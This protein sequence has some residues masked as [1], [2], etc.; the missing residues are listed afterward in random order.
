MPGTSPLPLPRDF[1]D[2]IADVAAKRVA[3][4]LPD[5]RQAAGSIELQQSDG[6]GLLVVQGRLSAP[7]P[8]FYFFTRETIPGVAGPLGGSVRF[9]A[10][11]IAFRIEP[12]GKDGAPMLVTHSID[13]VICRN[14]PASNPAGPRANGPSEAPPS[15]P[16]DIAFPEYQEGIIP[17]QSLPG[18]PAVIYIDF[19]GEKGP[20]LG[21]GNY[22]AE[23]T[24][25]MGN[26]RIK[27]IWQRVAED[28]QGFNI[29]VTT[30]RQVFDKAPLGNRQHC[31]VSTT[32]T[33]APNAGGV[34]H[35]YSF[36]SSYD[37]V[38]WVHYTDF[39]ANKRLASLI[40]HEVGHTL[41]L[42]H[43][44]QDPPGSEHVEYYAGQGSGETAWCPIMGNTDFTDLTQWCKGEYAYANNT[45]DDLAII[46]TNNNNVAYRTDDYGPVLATAGYLEILP[47]DS[48][49]N[50]GILEERSD[51]DALRFVT[52]GGF[53]MLTV[54]GVDQGSNVDLLAEIYDSSNHLIAAGNPPALI[55]ATVAATLAAGEYTLRVSGV[56]Y[57]D[58]LI[59]G[60]SDYGCNGAYLISGTVPGGVK[61]ER[62]SVEENRPNGTAVG[63]VI[64][65]GDHGGNPLSFMIASGN[66]GG[67]FAIH[68]TSGAITVANVA[69]L[70][71]EALST[72]W[73]DPAS[74][75]LF[76]A[77][78]DSLNPLKNEAIRVVVTVT[79]VNEAPTFTG[80][81]LT[82]LE[83]TTTGTAVFTFP[84]GD[85][86]HFDFATY[87]I[88]AGNTG[89]AFEI[90][91][92]TG[93]LL[94]AAD[95]EA[96]LVSTYQLSIRAT[97]QAVPPAKVDSLVTIHVLNVP[98][99]YEPGSIVRTYFEE[100]DGT[101]VA[102]LTN[103]PNFPENPYNE[104]FLT[105][106]DG[107]NH[108][109][110]YGSTVRGYLIPPVSGSYTFWISTDD[111]GE[112]WISSNANP[113]G[114]TLR[115]AVNGYSPP[116]Q[117]TKFPSQASAPIT[118]TAG[119]PYY[120][121][122]RQKEWGGG[123][124]VQVAWQ[125]PGIERQIIPGT[126]LVP[127]Y[128][129]YAPKVWE[130][131]FSVR[132]GTYVGAI[133][134]TVPVTDAN[135]RD[136]YSFAITGGT[137]AGVFD[138]DSSTGS[139]SVKAG[140]VLNAAITP[141]YTL[142]VS[143]TDSGTPPLSD[144]ATMTINVVNAATVS[145][146][147]IVQEIWDD[148]YGNDLA[149]FLSDP[150]FPDWPSS[151]WTLSSFDTIDNRAESYGS[152]IRAYVIPPISGT[153]TFYI[154]SDDEGRLLLSN[155]S[156]PASATQIANVPT[157]SDRDEYNKFPE[158]TSAPVNLI[159]GQRYYIETLHKDGCCGDFVQVAWTGPGI[160][161][162]TII[163]GSALQ[164]FDI[165]LP[166]AFSPASYSYTIKTTAPNGTVVGTV[167]ASDP[168]N[169]ELTYA[170]LGGNTFGA[171][172]INPHSGAISVIKSTGLHG[173]ST[174]TLQ[175]GVQDNGTG[176]LYSLKT[177][178]ATATISIVDPPPI[179]QWTLA[180]FGT[181][182]APGIAGYLDN[183][184]HDAWVNLIE[185]ALGLN[186]LLPD[187]GGLVADF[188]TIG[189]DKF[190]RLT[191][192]KNP[193][194]FDIEPSVEVTGDLSAPASWTSAGTTVEI[195][196]P[197]TLR[198]RDNTPVS[199][200]SQRFI[201]LKVMPPP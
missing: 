99:G 71:Y 26:D 14:F 81:E 182:P 61:P 91:P 32:N 73:D 95:L 55:S 145:V 193:T 181:N 103:D 119:T 100:I 133:F 86:D 135:P 161:S 129:N 28:F 24:P 12:V 185:Y 87:S 165:N 46:A 4:T 66:T 180:K 189:P 52:T 18:A 143:V 109:D 128:Q 64:P 184:D 178:T 174:V 19:D 158:Q 59:D 5:G 70:N 76:I 27:E 75:Q 168:T 153:Y 157:Y 37:V 41:G 98:D 72:Q 90:D 183:P 105:N 179:E 2:R 60:Y 166:P 36:T 62:F 136:T 126:Y 127:Y 194:A 88:L 92:R 113:A 48:V 74:F 156:N 111:C 169:D 9:D 201:R 154:A 63:T 200:A 192:T 173:A 146:D 85:S 17:L 94:V 106:F 149:P 163:P 130:A 42:F 22:D 140:A 77:V 116:L 16:T 117:W 82:I 44:G 69:Q 89:E 30:D 121:E 31:L 120:I 124:H 47:D 115:A 164:A 57:G 56:G 21:W 138:V 34:A 188:E 171:F 83:H 114:A 49:S 190:L 102:D 186:P 3:F 118:L 151:T 191:V 141:S 79:D 139:I 131:T 150:R 172:G 20:L 80:A 43:D 29:N 58:P 197:T 15:H 13:Q 132:E 125:G 195:N 167:S 142:S 160:A 54:S 155:S 122:A 6:D 50:E 110:Y 45:E 176:G 78:T 148:I 35:F 1:L 101:T 104:E 65:R 97:D 10:S 25:G 159:A 93:Q 112:L 152:R 38:C 7:E 107:G 108:G 175:I 170:I 84:Q 68:P 196:T 39:Q 123:D 96:S 51:V 187:S 198:V 53:V 147:G 162:R 177:A 67:A 8:G 40:S 11:E 23:P 33:A 199:A 134:G 144:T 137:G